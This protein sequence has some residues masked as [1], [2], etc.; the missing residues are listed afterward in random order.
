MDTQNSVQEIKL[1]SIGNSKGV[2]L[3]KPLLQKYAISNPLI[4]EETPEGI[5]LRS[6]D[7]S[8]LSWESSYKQMA[9]EQ[10]NWNGFDYTL[11]DGIE[12]DEFDD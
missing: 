11:L 1:V 8:K 3:L 10:E 9:E 2:R 7:D 6:K 4:L 5:L 12:H